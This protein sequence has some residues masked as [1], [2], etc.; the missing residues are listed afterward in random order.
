MKHPIPS[1]VLAATISGGCGL[2]EANDISFNKHI[3]PILADRCFSCHG[4]DSATRKANLRLDLEENA[5]TALSSG[6]TAIVP[7]KP[8]ESEVMQRLT[9]RDP[10]EVMPPRTSKLTVSPDEIA[11]IR[12]WI[13]QGAKWER[14]WAFLPPESIPPPPMAD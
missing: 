5:K 9:H 14:H 13:A 1:L 7:G 12:K 11:Q 10:D 3:R 6:V 4:P 2:L 8:E